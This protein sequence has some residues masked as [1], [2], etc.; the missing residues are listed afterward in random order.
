MQ[1]KPTTGAWRIIECDDSE[2]RDFVNEVTYVAQQLQADSTLSLDAKLFIV[3]LD[4]AISLM[5]TL[6]EINRERLADIARR[7]TV[8]KA[9][10]EAITTAWHQAIVDHGDIHAEPADEDEVFAPFAEAVWKVDMTVVELCDDQRDVTKKQRAQKAR[11][12]QILRLKAHL[13]QAM[14]R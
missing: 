13:V 1:T 2:F 4:E 11:F 10:S 14:A 3:R 7:L 8:A 5:E 12:M 6:I 9:A